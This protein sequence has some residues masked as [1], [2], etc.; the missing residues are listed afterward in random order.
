MDGPHDL[1]GKDGFGP[2]D[3][4][5]PEFREDW[6][7]RQ[8]ALSKNL[9]AVRSGTIDWWRH[10]VEQMHPVAYLSEPYFA[11]W[12]LNDLAQGVDCGVFT[13]QE[14]MTGRAD[15]PAASSPPAKSVP[16]LK[17]QMRGENRNFSGPSDAPPRFAIGDPVRTKRAPSEGHTRLPAYARAAKGVVTHHHGA[18][19]F[20]DAG[21]LGV[22]EFQHL[23]TVEFS[24]ETLWDGDAADSVCLDLWESY[25]EET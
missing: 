18:H 25:F 16:E 8:W 22:H 2:V 15:Q 17:A 24:A 21:A 19:L 13:L 3:V 11:K 14:A 23:Y 6:E 5:A 20:P 1:G 10:G 12:N 9:P 4:N 7:R